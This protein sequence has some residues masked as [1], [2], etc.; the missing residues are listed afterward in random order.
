MLLHAAIDWAKHQPSIAWIDL[1]VF[2]DNPGAQALYTRHGF[3]V[4]GRMPDRFRVDGESL[5]DISMTLDVG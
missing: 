2:S 1:G 3:E 4:L 5:E